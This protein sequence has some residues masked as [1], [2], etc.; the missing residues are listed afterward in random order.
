MGKGAPE[1]RDVE[2]ILRESQ[3][4]LEA[5]NN[6]NQV[7]LE[8]LSHDLRTP[9]NT[10]IGFADMIEQEMLGPIQV[11]QYR[12]YAE[13]IRK[14]GRSMLDILND[15]LDLRR[16]EQIEKSEKDFRHIIQL[17]PD[18][19]CVCRGGKIVMINP[20]GANMLGL[21][22]VDT[23]I[24]RHFAD[25]V[26][27]EFLDLLGDGLE[28]LI[29]EQLRVPIKFRRGDGVELDV[30][31]AALPYEEDD[32]KPESGEP[33]I[34]LMARDVSERNRAL[35][36]LA[37]R[38]E[39]IRKIMDTVA[40]GIITIDQSGTIE[41]LN[42]AAEKIFGYE[43]S[44]LV[45]RNVSALMPD[46]IAGQHDG[47]LTQYTETGEAR[48]IGSTIE[49]TGR[50]KD[51]TAV[52]IELAVSVLR[53]G[54]RTVYIGAVRDIAERKENENRLRT[55][56]TTDPLTK[57]PNR[58][59][60]NE[61]L[62]KAIETASEN[63]SKVAVIFI[64]LDNF[65]NINDAMGHL[66]GD[67]VIRAAGQRLQA[68]V[69]G[70]G[71]TVAH[72]GGDEFTVILDDI[73]G[74]AEARVIAGKMLGALSQPFQAEG[75]DLYTSGSLG[76]AIYPDHANTRSE[77]IRNVDTA[78]HHAK[79]EGRDN[80]QFYTDRLSTAVQRRVEIESSLRRAL[81][82][83]EFQL[84]YQAKVDL[85][86]R[87][88]TGAEALLR[89]ESP[90]LGMVPPD[91]FVPVAEDAGLI[92]PIG[93]WVLYTACRQAQAWTEAGADPIQVGVN[94][95]ARQFLQGDLT[96]WVL[97]SLDSTGLD[98]ERLDLE[99]TE[100][101][102][103]ENPDQTIRTLQ[104]LKSCGVTV[105]MDDFGTG[106][107]S[108]SYLTRFPLDSLKVDRAFVTNLPD[109][110]DAVAIARAIVSMAKNL[111]LHIVAEGVETENQV[112]FLHALGC[113]VGQGYLF[114]KPLPNDEFI[115]LLRSN[116]L[117]HSNPDASL[118]ASQ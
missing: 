10:I 88:I 111:E 80:F 63:G 42:P 53:I 98:P 66:T 85:D 97:H 33:A 37:A 67:R 104:V 54:Q 49:Q 13:D 68:C 109:D 82:S 51:G 8:T 50:R 64:D 27:P 24:G 25:F 86:S 78:A 76:V 16:F 92:V 18:L 11:P 38:E 36:T 29:A 48:I 44:E 41:T 15:V 103:V 117:L 79:A 52:P 28:S 99:L 83:D 58:T 93:E 45:G 22:P 113:H 87:R 91:E 34:M 77:L 40:D 110:R 108:L 65:K 17:A 46:E 62:D 5:A 20:A 55:L 114:S 14:S 101:M 59:L 2:E 6:A 95:S 118:A 84:H 94:L 1:K 107:S 90:E 102:L 116:R 35:R 43:S 4:Q 30:E 3:E 31:I 81:G 72:I 56:A 32:A 23:L 39:H 26:H 61:R 19:I 7:L 75:R 70:A 96:E 69:A 71:D 12:A 57:M 21:W 47:F 60:F 9:L 74:E 112:G 115:E 100:S 73:G 89:W 105:S 106:Y